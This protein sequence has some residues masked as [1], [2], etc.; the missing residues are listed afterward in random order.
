M[1]AIQRAYKPMIEIP[2]NTFTTVAAAEPGFDT[3][4]LSHGNTGNEM[5]RATIT[6]NP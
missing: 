6:I 2:N 4:L 3:L 1:D 5:T